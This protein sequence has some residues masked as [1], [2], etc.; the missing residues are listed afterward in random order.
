MK[1][2]QSIILIASLLASSLSADTIELK[3]G[4]SYQGKVLSEDAT[5]YLVE[6]HHSSSIKDHR[7]I[8][9][10]QVKQIISAAKDANSFASVKSSVPTPDGLPEKSYAA[11]IKRASDFLK[12]FPK[13]KHTKEVK[14][15]LNTLDKEMAVISQGGIKLDGH[16]ISS[17]DIEANAYDIHARIILNKT[18]RLAKAG[19]Y[20][21]SLREWENLQQNYAHS[22]AYKD[23]IKLVS[24]VLKP[25]KKELS[26]NLDSLEAR[27]T[28][29]KAAIASLETNDR[30][31]SENLLIE[32]ET[33]Y[34]ALIEKEERQIKTK[35][36][37][38]D[39]FNKHA[40]DYNLRSVNTTMKKFDTTDTSKI[41]LAGPDLRGAWSALAKDDLD[42]VDL[43]LKS[44]KPMRLP[45]EYID[46]ITTQL[47][48][49]RTTQ[50]DAK[51]AA[52]EQALKE[53][54]EEAAKK[55]KG[56]KK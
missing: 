48:A 23:A 30:R 6:I 31:R 52:E 47:T 49:K 40:L 2:H 13:S 26:R 32:K 55:K 43:R 11:R 4:T 28:N 14:S 21:M 42:D 22:A 20:Q 34:A 29:R 5:S 10:D 38:V 35:W 7:R 36:L 53:A 9:K 8:P 19:N 54:A 17:S 45:A 51:K 27:T 25:Y 46:P 44:L 39:P 41:K 12:K 37:T 33:I 50:A 3:S 16:L 18:K 15:I 1:T 56:K 24:R